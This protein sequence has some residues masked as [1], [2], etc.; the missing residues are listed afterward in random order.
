MGSIGRLLIQGLYVII[1]AR[2][3]GVEGFGAF[4]AI[5]AL[6]TII[7][8]FSGLG[9]GERTIMYISRNP[10]LLP[11]Y[12]GNSILTI[13]LTGSFLAILALLLG[14]VVLSSAYSWMFVLPVILSELCFGRVTELCAQ[15]FQG[16]ERLNLTATLYVTSSLIKLIAILSFIGF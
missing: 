6:L 1:L 11:K 5:M 9:S 14:L 16:L 12:L 10:V 13:L 8:P 4:A 3:L 15:I 2:A 7:A